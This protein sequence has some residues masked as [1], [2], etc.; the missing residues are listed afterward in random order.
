[1]T[2]TERVIKL[3]NDMI[4]LRWDM[5]DAR[6]AMATADEA[7]VEDLISELDELH[8]EAELHLEQ[9]DA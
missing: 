4:A 1:M 7:A 9:S 5:V 2:L 3:K 6:S 8:F